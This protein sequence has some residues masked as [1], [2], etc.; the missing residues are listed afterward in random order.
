MPHPDNTPRFDDLEGLA[1]GDIAALPPEM[2]L[3]LQPPP[4]PETARLNPLRARHA[5]GDPHRFDAAAPAA[6]ACAV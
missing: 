4:P 1:L 5:S 3:D 2:L 6:P